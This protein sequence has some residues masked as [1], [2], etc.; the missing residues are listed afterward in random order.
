[1]QSLSPIPKEV[2]RRSAHCGRTLGLVYKSQP[3]FFPLLSS[4]LLALHSVSAA[5]MSIVYLPPTSVQP[6]TETSIL[7]IYF[8][9]AL[10][11][12]ISY[13]AGVPSLP[14]FVFPP[15]TFTS[16]VNFR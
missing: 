2:Q 13:D 15:L 8:H 11:M 14:F 5:A 6:W 16:S 3:L 7:E 12:L 10:A 1:M 9:T 4:T